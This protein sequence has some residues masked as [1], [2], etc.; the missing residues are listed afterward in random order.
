MIGKLAPSSIRL[1]RCSKT[2]GKGP[3][4]VGPIDIEIAAGET[5]VILGP[6]GCGKTT[7]LRMIAGLEAP[8]VGGTILFGN[9]DVT[10][11]PIERRNIG[12]VFQSYALFPNLDV[13]GNISYGL[14]VRGVP[15]EAR[16]GRARELI[17]MM[18]LEP[19]AERRIDQLSGGQKQRVAL[20]RALAVEPRAM[21]LDEALTALDAKLRET[22]RV[23][24]DTLLRRLG[25]TTVYVTHDQAEAMSVGD[26]I[27][28]MDH[29][30]IAQVGTP[31][32]IYHRPATRFVAE[33]I[34]TTNRVPGEMKDGVFLCRAGRIP[35]PALPLDCREILFRPEHVVLV[36]DGSE[37]L[38]GRIATSFFLGDRTRLLVDG[39]GPE[40]IT[41]ETA[42]RREFA[43]GESVLVRIRTDA[44]MAL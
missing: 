4:S 5:V 42:S 36:E 16:E 43:S 39:F 31:R 9:D 37:G 44:L 15:R 18:R 33:F 8:D 20:A 1:R 28:V 26:R 25:I 21:L 19:F 30:R 38:P 7:T 35:A 3:T 12:M 32:E 17:A 11:L 27:V 2:F 6:S 22:L 14:R 41:V 24:I 13:I 23:E 29:G 10:P 40:P 34:G